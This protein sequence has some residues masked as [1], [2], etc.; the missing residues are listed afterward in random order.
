MRT[1]NA[2]PDSYAPRIYEL[3]QDSSPVLPPLTILLCHTH[4][5]ITID[6]CRVWSHL[7]RFR[8]GSLV[9]NPVLRTLL[10]R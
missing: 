4:K 3:P 6:S 8:P 2:S 5:T 1:Q 9:G 7:L 10:D